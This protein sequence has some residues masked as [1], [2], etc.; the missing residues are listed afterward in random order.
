[1][2]RYAN[3]I[4]NEDDNPIEVSDE[5]EIGDDLNDQHGTVFD[6]AKNVPGVIKKASIRTQREFREG[7]DNDAQN[8]WASKSLVL[9]IDITD[10]VY[11]G[12]KAFV[13]LYAALPLVKKGDRKVADLTVLRRVHAA[14]VEAGKTQKKFN[15]GWWLES[16]RH[17]F[18]MFL[19]GM[20]ITDLKT[21]NDAFL[22]GLQGRALTFEIKRK[23]DQNEYTGFKGVESGVVDED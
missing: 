15:E 23:G 21:L 13:S 16:A 2:T 5:T 1:M 4:D 17:P 14:N 3:D 20:K 7:P 19:Q 11:K 6:A 18:K 9:E 22:I 10:G 12:R 8:P